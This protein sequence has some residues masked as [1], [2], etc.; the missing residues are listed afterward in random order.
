[1]GKGAWGLVLF[2]VFFLGT[3]E[4]CEEKKPVPKPYCYLR[5]DFPPHSYAKLKAKNPMFNY[6]MELSDLFSMRQNLGDS[7]YGFQE[8]DLGPLNG[9][10]LVYLK[11]FNTKDS[12]SKLINSANDLVDEHKIKADRIDF[13]QIIAPEKKVY[14]TFF[15]LRGNV[16][17][18]YQFYLT[19]SSSRFVRGEILLNCRPNYDSLRP[20]LDYLNVDLNRMLRTFRWVN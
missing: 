17:T 10:M 11:E 1:M 9:T 5:T 3:L 19:D 2:L 14:G 13:N 15:T 4:S 20:T 16:A 8:F 18:N 7:R 12:L 6:E